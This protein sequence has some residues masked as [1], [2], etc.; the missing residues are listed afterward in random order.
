METEFNHGMG[1]D[2]VAK[3]IDADIHAHYEREDAHAK[4][5]KPSAKARPVTSLEEAALIRENGAEQIAHWSGIA[6]NA[7]SRLAQLTES[8]EANDQLRALG[9]K[10]NSYQQRSGTPSATQPPPES[11]GGWTSTPRSLRAE[12]LVAMWKDRVAAVKELKDPASEEKA[13]ERRLRSK[14]RVTGY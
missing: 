9:A 2:L 10:L 1:Q 12:G 11:S 6:A 5:K 8:K 13:L 4:A 3:A 14:S 7:R